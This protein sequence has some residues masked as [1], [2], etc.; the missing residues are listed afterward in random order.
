[1][2]SQ[3]KKEVIT[4][5]FEDIGKIQFEFFAAFFIASFIGLIELIVEKNYLFGNLI[6]Y[7]WILIPFGAGLMIKYVFHPLSK[8]KSFRLEPV[9]VGLVGI[10]LMVLSVLVWFWVFKDEKLIVMIVTLLS[11]LVGYS[12]AGVVL[13][14]LYYKAV[15]LRDYKGDIA[16]KGGVFTGMLIYKPWVWVKRLLTTR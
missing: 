6:N 9:F 4:I 13:E 7:L 3:D 11:Y 8:K 10:I 5:R 1:M 14:Y 15:A 2:K 16:T 12:G